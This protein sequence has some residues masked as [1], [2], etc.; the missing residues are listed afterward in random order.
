MFFDTYLTYSAL[1]SIVV[2]YEEISKNAL[3][4]VALNTNFTDLYYYATLFSSLGSLI[5]LSLYTLASEALTSNMVD[6]MI[7]AFKFLILIALLIFI[8]GGI[9]RY[10]FDHLTKMG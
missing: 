3:F 8:R 4:W 10:R 5:S 1:T 2:S 9:P 6:S 7:V